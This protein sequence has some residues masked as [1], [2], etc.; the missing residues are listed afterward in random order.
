MKVIYFPDFSCT[1]GRMWVYGGT[2]SRAANSCLPFGVNVMLI[3]S[4]INKCRQREYR[5]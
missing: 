1:Q 3:I 2:W 5:F 4:N